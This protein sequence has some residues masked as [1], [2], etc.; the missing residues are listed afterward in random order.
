MVSR[1]PFSRFQSPREDVVRS[2]K[3]IHLLPGEHGEILGRLE[4]GWEKVACWSTKAAIS[5][6]RVHIHC[7]SKKGTP[8]LSIVTLKGLTDFNDFWHKYSG[9]NWPSNG[10]SPSHLTQHLLLRCL[11]KP[12]KRNMHWNEQQTWTNWRLDRI[13][14]WSR[15][16]ELVKYIVYLL[17]IVLPVKQRTVTRLT[18]NNVSAGQ[19]IGRAKRSNCW[20]A[21]PQTS[22]LRICGPPTALTSIQ[23]ITSSGGHATVGLSDDVQ[24]CGWTHEATGWYL[25]WSGAEH[26]WDWYQ[27]IEKPSACLCSH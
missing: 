2:P 4:V 15:W 27:R 1:C 18:D 10:D 14:I 16:S 23:S 12:N 9:H 17:T 24:E 20:S 8:T 13:K 7:V 11:G 5:L 26:Y 6:K 25:D 3:A 21:K 19:R 22:S